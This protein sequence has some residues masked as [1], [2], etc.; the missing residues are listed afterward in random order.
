MKEDFMSALEKVR[1]FI[2]ENNM[3]EK[4]DSVIVGLSG[5][6]DS[7]CLIDILYRLKDEIGF[8]ITAVHVNHGIRGEEAKRDMEFAAKICG[9]RGIKCICINC[10]IPEYAKENRLSEEEAGR[11][12]R[13]EIFEKV[14][15]EIEAEKQKGTGVKIAIAHHSNDS[16]ET[17]LH[18][19]CRGSSLAGIMGIKAV[20]GSIIRPI[21]CLFRDEIEHYLSQNKISY[22]NDSTNF[23]LDYT[24]NKIRNKIIPYLNE[25]I[26]SRSAVHIMETAKDISEAENY[27]NHQA[28][29]IFKE[30]FVEKDSYLYADK[31]EILQLENMMQKRIVR[32][33][34]IQIAGRQKDITRRHIEDVIELCKKQSGRYIM[35][36]Y[37]VTAQNEGNYL[38]LKKEIDNTSK[39]RSEK[40]NGV[41]KKCSEE[42]SAGK[43]AGKENENEI[44]ISLA[45]EYIFG[46]YQIKTELI[47][48]ER[49]KMNISILKKY[50]K[51]SEKIYTKWFDC[52]KICNTVLLRTRK[53]GD[54]ITVN[55]SGGTKKIK[56]Y[57]IDEKIPA[58]ER[59]SILCVADGQHIM[60][61][62]GHRISEYYKVSGETKKIIKITI[63]EIKTNRE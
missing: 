18:N 21:L 47:D 44:D 5:G 6:A 36:P 40:E 58:S 33:A 12:K 10:D 26:N 46:K 27:I 8:D 57:F 25:N 55:S 20:N 2:K 49:E 42:D 63:R 61:I 62:Y 50:I 22:I 31:K 28:E 48:V 17:F 13:Y 14:R 52:D 9:E 51:N 59:N 35:L 3:I 34:V 56:S 16:V 30:I 4:N 41:I 43:D 7:V 19:L 32:L 54:F 39:K 24:R 1:I 11:I 45:G 37:H 38:I 23:S 15:C 60:W 29:K 53:T